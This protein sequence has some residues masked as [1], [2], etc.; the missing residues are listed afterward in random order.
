MSLE[1]LPEA[2]RAMIS[3]QSKP[4]LPPDVEARL[5]SRLDASIGAA[6][7]APPLP[8]PFALGGVK[9]AL[10]F[11]SG[12]VTGAL[13]AAALISRPVVVQPPL[14]APVILVPTPAPTPP[15]PTPPAPTPPA[16]AVVATP[17]VDR[18]V[19][20]KRSAP[21]GIDAG[22]AP[23][24]E[25]SLEQERRLLE[26]ARTALARGLTPQAL[27]LLQRHEQ[28]FPTG[29][30]AEERDALWVQ[31]LSVAGQTDAARVRAARFR[32]SYPDS[33]F[34]P[35]VERALRADGGP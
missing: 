7:A 8:R 19:V 20:V 24:A 1:P 6:F 26:P 31:T 33:L 28:Q 30:L 14:P 18:P 2:L 35:I 3:A 16:P 27:D 29:V 12:G 25:N 4:S 22:V 13:I 34:L 21:S 17:V 11:M 23:L 32:S 15:A 9:G 10:L 5:L